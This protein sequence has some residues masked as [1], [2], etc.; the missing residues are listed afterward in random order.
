MKYKLFLIYRVVVSCNLSLSKG[1][2]SV[3][4]LEIWYVKTNIFY[5]LFDKKFRNI[6]GFV[7]IS[8][9]LLQ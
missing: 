3:A 7:W 2:I 5:T 1:V 4:Y 9:V 8:L 6:L